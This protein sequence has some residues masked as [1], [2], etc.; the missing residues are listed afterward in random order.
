[1][2]CPYCGYS[3]AKNSKEN[4][5]VFTCPR[6]DYLFEV[7]IGRVILDRILSL[8]FSSIFYTPIIL[9]IDYYLSR[10]LYRE[11]SLLSFGALLAFVIL[12]SAF[13]MFFIWFITTGRTAQIFIVKTKKGKSFITIIKEINPLVKIAVLLLIFVIAAPIIF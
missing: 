8:P 11:E 4:I 12:L 2:I 3:K 13:M 7:S 5:H 6:C 10:F 9:V 1:M